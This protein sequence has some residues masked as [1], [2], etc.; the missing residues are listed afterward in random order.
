VLEQIGQVRCWRL[1]TREVLLP[2]MLELRPEPSAVSLDRI[3]LL[4]DADG[5]DSADDAGDLERQLLGSWE[6]VDARSDDALHGAGEGDIHQAG[7]RRDARCAA[8]DHKQP[9]VT[10]GVGELL[11]EEGIAAA[12]G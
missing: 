10:Q 6:P 4:E 5:E 7:R 3:D 11:G 9:R 2:K 12:S 1:H 8:F